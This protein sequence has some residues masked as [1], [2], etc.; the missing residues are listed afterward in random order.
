MH[1]KKVIKLLLVFSCLTLPFLANISVGDGCVFIPTVEQW[2]SSYEEKQIGVINYQ[3]GMENLTL[4]IDIKNSSLQTDQAFWIFPI[5]SDPED[6]HVSIVRNIPFYYYGIS[7]I[8]ESAER[9]LGNAFL[10][11]TLSQPY[12][13][14]LPAFFF[15]YMSY[16]IGAASD[17]DLIVHEHIEQ[18]GLTSELISA[19]TSEAIELYLQEKN[20]TL[21]DNAINIIDEYIGK[22]YSFVTSWISD[23]ETFKEEANAN[24]DNYWY[25]YDEPFYILGVS[26]TFPTNEIYYPL[27]LTAL[28]DKKIIPVLIQINGYVTPKNTFD[29]MNIKYLSDGGKEYTQMEI[30]VPSEDFTED[31]WIID[32]EPASIQTAKFILSNL[33]IMSILIFILCSMLASILSA[34]I[35]FF[36]NKPLFGKFALLG[37][38]NFLSIFSV[39]IL[40]FVFKIDKKFLKIPIEKNKVTSKNFELGFRI[41]FLVIGLICL[42]LFLSI[43]ITYGIGL[44]IMSIFAIVIG[45]LMFVYGGFKNPRVTLFTGL[46]SLFFFIFII[47]FNLALVSLL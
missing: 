47:L 17:Q 11:T 12:I 22:E 27:K 43:F 44:F 20:I 6:A 39:F 36:K 19:N 28:Y 15:F 25:Y 40:S 46:F 8:R 18:F 29:N 4:V 38:G 42:A 23:L 35:T 26:V 21:T 5:A 14:A 7:D 31:L 32:E 3:N 10:V 9:A 45:I 24:L 2:I 30:R 34:A 13:I 41:T 33:L 37:F 16:G 1:G